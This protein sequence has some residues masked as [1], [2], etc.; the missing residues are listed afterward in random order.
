MVPAA[1]V[2]KTIADLLPHLDGEDI[3]STGEIPITW[4]TSGAPRNSQQGHPLCGRGDQRWCLGAGTRLLHDDWWRKDVVKHLDPI[5]STLAPGVGDIAAYAGTR[6]A[7]R[8][9]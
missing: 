3:S 1:V 6:E 7:G 9:V 5:F 8:H 2:D 4:M